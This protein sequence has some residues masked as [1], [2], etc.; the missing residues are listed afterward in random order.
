MEVQQL[1]SSLEHTCKG[2]ATGLANCYLGLCGGCSG[3]Q[4]PVLQDEDIPN[5]V[6]GHDTPLRRT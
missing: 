3:V 6:M 4:N 5:V 1:S 2:S